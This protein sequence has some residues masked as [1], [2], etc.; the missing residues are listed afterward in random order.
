[1]VTVEVAPLIGLDTGHLMGS[2][3]VDGGKMAAEQTAWFPDM[4]TLKTL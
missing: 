4:V 2:K 3:R 1:M